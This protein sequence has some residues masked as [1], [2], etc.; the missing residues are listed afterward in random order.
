[1]GSSNSDYKLNPIER[2]SS[3]AV[4]IDDDEEEDDDEED[5]DMFGRADDGGN[6]EDS[7]IYGDKQVITT[8]MIR[9]S[10]S[11]QY[12]RESI[13]DPVIP[14]MAGLEPLEVV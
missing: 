10:D 5:D 8:S 9:P 4:I 3:T 6:I 1:M 2:N 13:L 7:I 12:G 11:S 14:P